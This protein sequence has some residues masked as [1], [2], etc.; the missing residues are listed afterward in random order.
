MK[1]PD[2]QLDFQVDTYPVVP[3]AQ[4]ATLV[5]Q[6]FTYVANDG[7]AVLSGSGALEKHSLL[8]MATWSFTTLRAIIRQLCVVY[9]AL[10]FL[11]LL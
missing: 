10:S 7:G 1:F 3:S 8:K 5:R 9:Y 11:F 4:P 6:T 2:R